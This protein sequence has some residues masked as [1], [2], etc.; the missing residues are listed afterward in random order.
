MKEMITKYPFQKYS[1]YGTL[2]RVAIYFLPTLFFS[3]I[4]FGTKKLGRF[5]V[6]SM[7]SFGAN[8]VKNVIVKCPIKG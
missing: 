5:L 4:I 2:E 6:I 8:F 3:Q 7:L 1:P